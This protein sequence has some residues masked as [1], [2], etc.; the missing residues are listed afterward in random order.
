MLPLQGGRD[1]LHNTELSNGVSTA[2]RRYVLVLGPRPPP[3]RWPL[4]PLRLCTE[5]GWPGPGWR[6]PAPPL[7][8]RGGLPGGVQVDHPGRVGKA[9]GHFSWLL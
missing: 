9:R 4:G 1:S 5:P 8:G 6:R 3:A 7:G 2:G